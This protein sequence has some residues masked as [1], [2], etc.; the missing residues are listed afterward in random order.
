ME[1]LRKSVALEKALVDVK[2][3]Q[4]ELEHRESSVNELKGDIAQLQEERSRLQI[5]LSS[6]KTEVS[7][8]HAELL[9]VSESL[10]T[11]QVC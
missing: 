10:A 8:L 11:A 7:M 9:E 6:T 2:T 1:L 5:E 3:L 4:E